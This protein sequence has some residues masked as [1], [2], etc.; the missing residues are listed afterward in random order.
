M[1]RSFERANL[2]NLRI[3]IIFNRC[4][5]WIKVLFIRLNLWIIVSANL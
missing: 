2:R 5:L 1:R 4:N 3:K